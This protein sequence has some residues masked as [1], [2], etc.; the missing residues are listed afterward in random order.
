FRVLLDGEPNANHRLLARAAK[1]G[2]IRHVLTTNVDRFL[3]NAFAA[4]GVS[5]RI[6][7]SSA[8]FQSFD[9]QGQPTILKLHGCVSV[10]KSITATVE[11]ESKGMPPEKVHALDR[12]LQRYPLAVWGYSGADLKIELD[13]MRMLSAKDGSPGLI[14][15]LYQ[16]GDY[17]E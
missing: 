16:A 4:E 5:C 17:N 3:E 1:L 6:C 14:W 13:Y 15:S 7:I 10:P 8:D 9:S 11:A 12:L 2:L